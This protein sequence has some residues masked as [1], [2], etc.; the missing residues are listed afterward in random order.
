MAKF[1]YKMENIL[2]I[3]YK[4]EEEAKNIY[5][6][7]RAHLNAE[8]DKLQLL[9]NQKECYEVKL[10]QCYMN[11]LNILSIRKCEE[12]VEIMKYKIKEQLI[13]VN[14]AK[15]QLEKARLKLNDAMIERKTHEKLKENAFEDFKED[16]KGQEKKVIDEL[17]SFKFNNKSSS[18]DE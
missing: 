18:E 11:T 7:A 9:D 3:K 6:A 14:N 2:N 17:V 12:A 5:G 8:E 4:L 10:R 15:I 13:A 1:I 16:I